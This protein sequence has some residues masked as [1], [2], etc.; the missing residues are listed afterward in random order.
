MRRSTV[1]PKHKVVENNRQELA[2]RL[3]RLE[4]IETIRGII[5]RL[6]WD[7]DEQQVSRLLENMTEDVLYKVGDFGDYRG[8]AAVGD[9]LK[10]IG[11]AFGMRVHHTTNQVVRIE[12]NR[13]F[14]RC[15]YL[16]L[17]EWQET[18]LVASGEYHDELIKRN[19]RWLIQVR[20]T[21]ITFLSTL[22]EGWAKQRILNIGQSDGQ[23]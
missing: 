18:S 21:R 22:Q 11:S 7:A 5:A 3:S 17:L 13:A 20:D 6:N 23:S 14:S 1:G 8:S 10:Q 12:G 15:Y 19:G 16:A 4:D 2:A 9:F